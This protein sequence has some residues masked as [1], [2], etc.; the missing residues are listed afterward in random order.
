MIG[1]SKDE[2]LSG[3]RK[4]AGGI[5]TQSQQI[6]VAEKVKNCATKHG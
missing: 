1:S 3:V 4:S 2:E 6:F 5:H